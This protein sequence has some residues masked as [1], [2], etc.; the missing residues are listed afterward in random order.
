MFTGLIATT[1]RIAGR[2]VSGNSGQLEL[3][4][5]KPLGKLQFGESI[6]VNGACLTLEAAKD[7]G[8]LVFHVLAETFKRTNLGSIPI[9]GVVNLERALALGD[10]LGGHLVTGHIDSTAPV[11][12]INSKDGDYEY[13]VAAPESIRPFLVEKGSIAIDGTSLTLVEVGEDFFT[14]HLIPVT[15][16]ETALLVRRPGELVNLEADLLGKYV[17]RQLNLVSGAKQKSKITMDSLKN[18]GW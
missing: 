11:L 17:Q 15:A 12:A 5:D 3:K 8:I 16:D 13:K 10:R 1:A 2:K 4:P 14:V 18:A 9:G 6:A 7:N